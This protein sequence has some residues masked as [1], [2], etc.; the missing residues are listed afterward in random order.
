M[1][2]RNKVAVVTGAGSG[3]GAA[4][5]RLFAEEGAKVVVNDID[6]NAG[7]TVADEI[8]RMGGEA[9]YVH[10][11][12][13]AEDQVAAMMATTVEAFGGL[14]LFVNNAGAPHRN[15][16][17]LDVTEDEFDRVFSTN[18]K[19]IFFTT[20]HGVPLM[21]ARGGGVILHTA[22]T[23]G[24]R[25]RPGLAWYNAS[26]GAV[27]NLTLTMAAELAKDGI[28]V[29]ALCPV[30]TDTPMLEQFLGEDT[31]ERRAAFVATI[32]MGRFG[33]PIDLA[34][35]AVWLASDD[36]EFIT[37]VLLPVDGGRVAY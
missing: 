31:P 37:G 36:A 21:K 10:A 9:R 16:P 12:V 8:R 25:P 26:K 4:T 34:R 15:K 11:D 14:D 29:N 35:A 30:A 17:I 5:A 27:C 7:G 13:T 20:R 6:D 28:R 23:A 1:R 22:S 18:V 3:F 19:S 32:P 2:L 33:R 24:L